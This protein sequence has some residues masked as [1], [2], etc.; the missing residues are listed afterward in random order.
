[1]IDRVILI[2]AYEKI[3]SYGPGGGPGLTAE[4]HG[5]IPLREAIARSQRIYEFAK[6]RLDDL[7][8]P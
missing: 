2:R 6:A 5:G 4:L 1:M 8:R 3:V 7:R